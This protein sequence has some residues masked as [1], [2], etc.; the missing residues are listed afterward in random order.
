[1]L[2]IHQGD[3]LEKLRE[4]PDEQFHCDVIEM[5]P[6]YVEIMIKRFYNDNPMFGKVKVL[7]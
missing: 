1:M 2:T 3:V 7:K 4:L 5:N 6:E